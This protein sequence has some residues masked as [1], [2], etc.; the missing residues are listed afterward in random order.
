MRQLALEI[1]IGEEQESGTN[2]VFSE[3]SNL[4]Y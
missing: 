2:Q 4:E 1:A 3:M